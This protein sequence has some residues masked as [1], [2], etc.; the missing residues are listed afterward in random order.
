M[1]LRFPITKFRYPV[2]Y[3]TKWY[4]VYWFPNLKFL[5][6]EAGKLNIKEYKFWIFVWRTKYLNWRKYDL[7]ALF[8]DKHSASLNKHVKEK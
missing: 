4:E 6:E 2:L 7:Q 5:G 1:K 3:Y 8:P